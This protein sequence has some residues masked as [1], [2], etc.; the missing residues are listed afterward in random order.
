MLSREHSISCPVHFWIPLQVFY[1]LLQPLYM[2]LEKPRWATAGLPG[3]QVSKADSK[4]SLLLTA[5]EPI[6]HQTAFTY[7]FPRLHAISFL[8]LLPQERRGKKEY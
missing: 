3:K 7:L 2:D 8:P 1:G 6:L 4:Q 5:G